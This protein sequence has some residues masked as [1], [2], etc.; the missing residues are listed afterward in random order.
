MGWPG[1][2]RGRGTVNGEAVPK[3]PTREAQ[4]HAPSL[5]L[6]VPGIRISLPLATALLALRSSLNVHVRPLLLRAPTPQAAREVTRG[7]RLAWQH[8]R[9][10]L[11]RSRAVVCPAGACATRQD[12]VFSAFPPAGPLDGIS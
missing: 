12:T 7:T 4:A 1:P 6:T 3:R 9:G 5:D 8:S 2:A 11:R 10:R